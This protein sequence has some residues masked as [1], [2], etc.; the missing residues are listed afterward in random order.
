M[1]AQAEGFGKDEKMT[2]GTM[3]LRLNS[4]NKQASRRSH[5]SGHRVAI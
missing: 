4:E 2:E 1:K 3:L 5:L